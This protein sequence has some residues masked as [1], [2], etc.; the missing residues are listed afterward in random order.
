M[1]QDPMAMVSQGPAWMD[2]LCDDGGQ[3][4][5][6]RAY[7]LSDGGRVVI[8]IAQQARLPAT[9][10]R[11]ASPPPA[12]GFGGY[13][14]SR[15]LVASELAAILDDV[16]RV[17]ALQ[18]SIRPNPLL[19]EVWQTAVP[20]AALRIPR[21]AH[22]LDLDPDFEVIWM[23]RFRS[24]TR[25]AVRK[26][27]KSGLEVELDTTGRLIPEFYSLLQMS[28]DRWARQR[29]KPLWI[30][31]WQATRRDPIH[32]FETMARHLGD[33]FRI[34]MARLDGRPAS[35]LLVLQDRN[36]YYT[37]GAMDP[38]LAGPTQANA[39]LHRMAMEDACK[40]GCQH[41]HMGETGDSR[42][43][44]QFKERFGAVARPYHEYRWERVPLTPMVRSLRRVAGAVLKRGGASDDDAS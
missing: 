3:Q 20:S 23:Q 44:T 28:F 32:K 13:L 14:A 11:L 24:G 6:S 30:S 26:A 12:W 16:S 25:T 19:D 29:R 37:R 41:Y 9:L 7:T 5:V 40:A 39:L 17:P 27:E 38:Q 1:Q 15:P 43:M 35:A 22:V 31:R 33:R 42:S 18:L 4:D 36:A 8:P 2:A 34:W 21:I 10:S